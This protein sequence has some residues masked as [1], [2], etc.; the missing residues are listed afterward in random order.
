MTSGLASISVIGSSGDPVIHERK[1]QLCALPVSTEG[2]H[3]DCG[4]DGNPGGAGGEPRVVDHPSSADFW[5][6]QGKK[7]L[8][9]SP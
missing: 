6:P 4:V 1:A 3:D 8:Q 2:C 5:V 7:R 9:L